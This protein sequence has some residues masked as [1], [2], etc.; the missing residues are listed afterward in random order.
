MT[1]RQPLLVFTTAAMLLLAL[2]CL[3]GLG[4]DPRQLTG[5]PLWLKPLKFS[6]SVLIYTA[7]LAWM[8]ALLPPSRTARR[9]GDVIAGMLLLEMVCI[10]GQAA[11]GA[12]SHFNMAVP[13]RYIFS[14]MGIAITVV[15][16]LTFVAS[17][18]LLRSASGPGATLKLAVAAGL[19][20]TAI[21]AG[22]GGLMLLPSP[23]QREILARG[24]MPPLLGHHTVGAPDGGPGL[25]LTHWSTTHGDLRVAHF[26]GLHGMQVIPLLAFL[27]LEN[28]R[29]PRFGVAALTASYLALMGI[30][31]LQ[32]YRAQPLL[33]PD[34]ITLAL[35]AS[36]AVL[37]LASIIRARG[38]GEPIGVT[39]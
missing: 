19:F 12:N 29:R 10:A 1:Q 38:T 26:V 18:L 3:L 34:A 31:L 30:V 36:W 25:P 28:A 32:A 2:I 33:E 6:L 27:L 39:V 22:L 8:L 14:L 4:L 17:F 20:V 16:V 24:E 9:V 11:R 15:F 23:E 13:D 35:L 21:G 5:A 37:S 7:T